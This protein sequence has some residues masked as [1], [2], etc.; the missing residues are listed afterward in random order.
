MIRRSTA[1]IL[2]RS[3]RYDFKS[4]KR[5]FV[6]Q[7]RFDISRRFEAAHVSPVE[8][9]SFERPADTWIVPRLVRSLTLIHFSGVYDGSQPYNSQ[10]LPL[11]ELRKLQLNDDDRSFMNRVKSQGRVFFD[12]P[13]FKLFANMSSSLSYRR[14]IVV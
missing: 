8:R 14:C 11:S 1:V 10:S 5:V 9:Y 7:I 12:C 4:G 3:F 2:Y 13:L 6:F